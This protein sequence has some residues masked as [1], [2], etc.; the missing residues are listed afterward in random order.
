M[1]F[2][3]HYGRNQSVNGRGPL[4]LMAGV[5][6]P[7]R[8]PT[9]DMEVSEVELDF[10]PATNDY[11]NLSMSPTFGD[12]GRS[13]TCR[14]AYVHYLAITTRHCFPRIVCRSHKAICRPD[15]AG[16]RNFCPPPTRSRRT[17]LSTSSSFAP[18]I[19]NAAYLTGI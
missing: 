4:W 17:V 13:W 6:S 9:T 8:H 11:L 7:R 3:G 10:P 15:K 1:R 14:S 5:L 2:G 18:N 19:H 12:C 16:G